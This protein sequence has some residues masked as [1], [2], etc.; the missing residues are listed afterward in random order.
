MVV[1]KNITNIIKY[2]KK[3]LYN[4]IFMYYYLKH[5]IKIKR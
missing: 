4:F 1:L 3:R 2:K 5:R